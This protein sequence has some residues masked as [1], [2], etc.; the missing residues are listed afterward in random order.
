MHTHTHVHKIHKI[1]KIHTHDEKSTLG[2]SYNK[3]NLQGVIRARGWFGGRPTWCCWVSMMASVAMAAPILLWC[4]CVACVKENLVY[5]YVAPLSP[6]AYKFAVPLSP[7]IPFSLR[8]CR[9]AQR[10]ESGFKCPQDVDRW[11]GHAY[12]VRTCVL[13]R[14]FLLYVDRWRGHAYAVCLCACL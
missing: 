5:V 9:W 7:P 10:E 2:L 12:I 3:N 1:H 11:R 6:S 8:V 14:N 13:S 4:V